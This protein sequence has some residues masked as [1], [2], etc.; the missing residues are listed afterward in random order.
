[1]NAC[2]ADSCNPASGCVHSPI[3]CDDVDAC[4]TD[5]CD[6]GTGCH[7]A[8]IPATS[9]VD[10]G[11]QL[12]IDC[13]GVTEGVP[14]SFTGNG[15]D[16]FLADPPE[17]G[18]IY[19]DGAIRV[20]TGCGGSNYRSQVCG[21]QLL[22]PTIADGSWISD[23]RFPTPFDSATLGCGQLARA[24]RERRLIGTITDNGQGHAVRVDGTADAGIEF[25]QDAANNFC[26]I[27]ERGPSC[28]FVL[29]RNDTANGSGASVAPYPGAQVSYADVTGA[30]R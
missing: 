2:T 8:A 9:N 16:A 20:F 6:P 17:C 19:L 3:T 10:G 1:G 5:T 11:W 4:T 22:V 25:W 24:F 29:L 23:E 30:G 18:T 27:T 7:H 12:N 15:H 26:A 21:N 14:I 28:S 13:G